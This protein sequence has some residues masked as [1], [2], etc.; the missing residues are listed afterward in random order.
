MNQTGVK[1]AISEAERFIAA[2]REYLLA[3]HTK[4]ESWNGI[5]KESGACRRAS[6]DLTRALSEMRKPG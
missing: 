1:K 6:L 2:A 4:K 3:D 5:P